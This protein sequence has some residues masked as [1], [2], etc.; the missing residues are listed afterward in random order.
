[1]F[2]GAQGPA[3]L[4]QKTEQRFFFI[5]EM[6]SKMSFGICQ[7]AGGGGDLKIADLI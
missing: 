6:P 1:M 4:S 7:L 5:I 2:L 3:E